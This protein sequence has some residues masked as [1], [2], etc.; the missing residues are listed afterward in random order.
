LSLSN[1]YESPET[2]GADASR[3]DQTVHATRMRAALAGM[4]RGAK[5]GFWTF[6]IVFW[7]LG[8]VMFVIAA[9]IPAFRSELIPGT[10]A[11]EIAISLG[12]N[13]FVWLVVI[14][15]FG[16]LYGS[17]PGGLIMGLAAA[18]GWRRPT[19]SNNSTTLVS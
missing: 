11:A 19:D 3:I 16:V 4:W 18:I 10:T 13:L 15:L 14:P 17:L 5:L 7:T 9:W 6:S 8:L 2:W 1:P 12:K